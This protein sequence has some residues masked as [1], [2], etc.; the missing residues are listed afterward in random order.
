LEAG[1][2]LL[3][4]IIQQLQRAVLAHRN[5]MHLLAMENSSSFILKGLM[6]TNYVYDRPDRNQLPLGQLYKGHYVV[7]S[8][9]DRTFKLQMSHKVMTVSIDCLKQHLGTASLQAVDPPFRGHPPNSQA[10]HNIAGV[11][12]ELSPEDALIEN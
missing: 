10:S 11:Q 9:I 6:Q 5:P 7:I 2:P 8:R 12:A 3:K 4:E 1:K